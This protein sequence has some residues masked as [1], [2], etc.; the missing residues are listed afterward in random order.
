TAFEDFDYNSATN[1]ELLLSE[2]KL[3]GATKKAIGDVYDFQPISFPIV[4]DRLTTG[5]EVATSEN[6]IAICRGLEGPR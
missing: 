6:V 5:Q 3:I 2:R 1:V 4:S